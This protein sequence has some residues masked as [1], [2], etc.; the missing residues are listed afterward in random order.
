VLAFG[1]ITA[2]VI[3]AGNFLGNLQPGGGGDGGD[4]LL[5]GDCPFLSD[6][7]A[8][9]V[10]GGSADA[11]ELEGLFDASIGIII[12][13]RVLP[14]APDCFVTEGQRAFLARIAVSDGNGA[15]VAQAVLD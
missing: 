6:A 11:I 4:A 9:T 2:F 13:K 8:A 1:L 7:E 10:L 12:D 14:D 5:G 15:G 3:F